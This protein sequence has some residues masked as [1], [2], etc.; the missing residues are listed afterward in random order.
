MITQ[1]YKIICITTGFLYNIIENN[2]IVS[3]NIKFFAENSN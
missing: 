1:N 2:M 3:N